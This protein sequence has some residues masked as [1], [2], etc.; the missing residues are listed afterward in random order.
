MTTKKICFYLQNRPIQ[1]IETGG[2]RYSDTSP[3]SVPLA[4][5]LSIEGA[6]GGGHRKVIHS[7][8]HQPESK[9]RFRVLMVFST[10]QLTI[11]SWGRFVDQ[12][13][14]LSYSFRC[15]QIN[16]NHCFDFGD[17]VVLLKSDLDVQQT[18]LW[19]VN[20]LQ[21]QTRLVISYLKFWMSNWNIFTYTVWQ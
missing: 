16:N 1:T 21:R 3:F 9:M 10:W 14:L 18:H 6:G 2:Q 5:C 4:R 17:T 7:S 19:G 15:D 8:R 13:L 12:K 20:L 11:H